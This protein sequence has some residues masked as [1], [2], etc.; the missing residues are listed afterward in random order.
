MNQS[1]GE[2]KPRLLEYGIGESW[3]VLVGRS[4]ADNEELSL[5]IARPRDWWFHVHGVPGS[6]V[7]LQA[8]S[9]D[10]PGRDVLK[11]AAAIAAYHSKA[12]EAGVVSVSCT[13]ASEV[14]KPRG[15]KLGTVAIRKETTMKVRP[16]IEGL[17]AAQWAGDSPA[18]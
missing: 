15:S 10:E 11:Q 9:G 13:R 12:R 14:S 3:R 2:H 6:H 17:T 16:S 4:D 7:V 5:R 18:T 8:L 1:G